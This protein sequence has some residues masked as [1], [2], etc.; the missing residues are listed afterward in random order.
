MCTADCAGFV[1]PIHAYPHAGESAAV[2]GGPV[3]RGGMF[4]SEYHGNLFFGDYAKGFIKHADLDANGDI[5]AV[6]D[7]D[8]Q[9]G[10]VVDLKVAPDGSLYYITYYPGALYR[11]TYQ[12]RRR[13]VPVA[14]P[15]PTSRRVSSR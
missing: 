15:P 8:D 5:T 3:Y 10:S 12:H 11:V 7:F 4:P 1:D 13:S 6:H 9:A 2:T 14:T